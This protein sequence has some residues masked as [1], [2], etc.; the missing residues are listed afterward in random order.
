MWACVG[1][2]CECGRVEVW[3]MNVGVCRWCECGCV[4]ES[5]IWGVWVW[6]MNRGVRYE[7]RGWGV[8]MGYI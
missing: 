3:D 1:V 5:M 6:G 4:W 7:C 2:W 8:N